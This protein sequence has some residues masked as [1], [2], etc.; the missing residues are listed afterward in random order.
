MGSARSAFRESNSRLGGWQRGGGEGADDA[1]KAAHHQPG[2]QQE[3]VA[4]ARSVLARTIAALERA[5]A[6]S[7]SLPG[8]GA[9]ASSLR[10]PG[11]GSVHGTGAVLP[12]A[13]PQQQ[14]QQQQWR[15]PV[16]P[17]LDIAAAAAQAAAEA[18]AQEE[19]EAAGDWRGSDG[20]SSPLSSPTS[21]LASPAGGYISSSS[22]LSSPMVS[23]SPGST[24]RTAGAAGAPSR[25]RITPTAL[26]NAAHANPLWNTSPQGRTAPAA[27]ADGGDDDGCGAAWRGRGT[28]SAA[29]SP[30]GF[31]GASFAGVQRGGA[32]WRQGGEGEAGA[33]ARDM[34]EGSSATLPP[35]CSPAA[36]LA[37]PAPQPE[38]GQ[39]QPD[40][41]GSPVGSADVSSM[42]TSW[43]DG[44]GLLESLLC[45][46]QL[47]PA[48][49]RLLGALMHTSAG[50]MRPAQPTPAPTHAGEEEEQEQED[51][52]AQQAEEQVAPAPP[53]AAAADAPEAAAVQVAAAPSP[54]ASNHGGMRRLALL[55]LGAAAG[56]AAA[57][58]AGVVQQQRQDGAVRRRGSA[59]HRHPQRVPP[60]REGQRVVLA[61]AQ[62]AVKQPAQQ[63]EL[64]GVSAAPAASWDNPDA[65]FTQG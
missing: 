63:Q 37:S 13:P 39:V 30:L 16:L 11:F 9:G 33:A 64:S 34:R 18:A 56:A 21:S 42:H 41:S 52:A 38:G 8:P 22:L 19:E 35:S 17:R 55:V 48:H 60:L 23:P 59:A 53:A 20:S 50:P 54:S 49:S 3:Q 65:I 7:A 27:H 5:A 2:G 10:S 24:A 6:D 45:P 40:G 12:P 57:V 15:R 29:P 26:L 25:H 46:P 32:R 58:A 36:R 1:R 43:D 44:G 14:Q 51:V 31:S 62:A 47:K 61:A 28:T 4:P